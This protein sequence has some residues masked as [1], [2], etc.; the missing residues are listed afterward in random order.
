MSEDAE[1]ATNPSSDDDAF[2]ELVKNQPEDAPD[3]ETLWEG[4]EVIWKQFNEGVLV[5][6]IILTEYIDG[7]GKVLKWQT[8]PDLA[9]WEMIGLLSQALIDL[10]SDSIADTIVQ[11]IVGGAEDDEDEDEDGQ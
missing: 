3:V 6:G 5:K 4:L 9:P 8:S 1:D 11:G 7:R 10:Q 2:A